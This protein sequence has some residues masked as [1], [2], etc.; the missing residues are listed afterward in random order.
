MKVY[1]ELAELI[2][3]TPMVKLNGFE[4]K[5]NIGAQIFAKLEYLNPAGSIKDR[6][7]LEMILD[8]EQKKLLHEGSVIIEPT[9]GNTGIGLAS[10]GASRG[11]RVILTMPE[12][13]SVER[14]LL[15]KA[16]G[17]EVVLTKASEGM[18]GAIKKAR[19]L[20]EEIPNSFIP[21]Q[22]TNLSN[23]LSHY[24]TTGPEIYEALSGKVDIL[25]A[26]IGTG[27]TISGAGKFLRERNNNIKIIGVEPFGSP[28]LSKGKIGVHKLQGIGAGFVPITLDIDIYDEI[29]AIKDSDAFKAAREVAL[30]DGVLV[31][32]SSGAVLEAAKIVG[33]RPI[34]KNKRIAVILPDGGA[35]YLSTGLFDGGDLGE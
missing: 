10:I 17:A 26:G 7:A 11:Y 16:Y 34:N 28:L 9:S 12:S 5:L 30:Y 8:A 19:E 13:M 24:K 14:I 18:K 35:K 27:G 6:V 1:Q 20:A 33:Q 15:L 22:F 23:P 3:N 29:L 21:G 32:I 31:G 4:E 2:G 25:I